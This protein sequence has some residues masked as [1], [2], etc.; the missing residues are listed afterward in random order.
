MGKKLI[1]RGLLGFP[2]GIAIGFVITVMISV[3]IGDGAFYP[4]TPGLINAMGNELGAVVLQTVLCGIMGS[5][6][7][8]ASVIWEIDS[9]SLAKQS[10]IYFSVACIAMLPIA[11]A[12]DWMDHSISG[13]LSYA[14]IFVAIFVLVWLIQY[15]VWKNKIRKMNDRVEKGSGMK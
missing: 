3:C 12:A 2:L 4:V 13:I 5:G 6:F 9:W 1:T 15:F 10:G 8:M 14:G 11:Y 7:A